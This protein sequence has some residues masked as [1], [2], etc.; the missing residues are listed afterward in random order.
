MNITDANELLDQIVSGNITAYEAFYKIMQPRLYSFCRKIIDDKEISRDV[1]Q[2]VFISFWENRV[3]LKI[4]TTLSAYVFQMTYF[5]CMDHLRRLK[6]ESKYQNYAALKIKESELSFFDPDY[7][8]NGSLFFNEIESQIKTAIDNLPEQCRNIFMMSRIEEMKNKEIAEKL[9]LSVRTVEAQ[10]YKAL[11]SL[12][13]EL[14]EFF[15]IFIPFIGLFMQ[16]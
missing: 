6:V 16:K 7:N 14:K 10:I 12:K 4:H 11:K 15:P 2:E 9:G 8:A 3:N 5:K 13:S 1:V